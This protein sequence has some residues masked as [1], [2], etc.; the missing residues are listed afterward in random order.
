MQ[1]MLPSLC[2][3]KLF[4]I[5]RFFARILFRLA[6]T[7]RFSASIL[8]RPRSCLDYF[9]LALDVCPRNLIT[10]NLPFCGTGNN[11]H[12]TG[13]QDEAKSA[14]SP[15]WSCPQTKGIR[16]A[17][18]D[19]HLTWAVVRESQR[20]AG[21]AFLGSLTS[22]QELNASQTSVCDVGLWALLLLPSNQTT[23]L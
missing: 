3:Q 13:L 6:L 8:R 22:L 7:M 2:P 23:P 18:E 14:Y 12:S 20:R 15:P 10:V 11:M 5:K 1:R 4:P 19:P 17:E 21:F 16:V 9:V